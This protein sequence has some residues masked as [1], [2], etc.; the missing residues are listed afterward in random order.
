MYMYF[1]TC[2]CTGNARVNGCLSCL[3]ASY[4][5]HGPP[6]CVFALLAVFSSS[7]VAGALSAFGGVAFLE[8]ADGGMLL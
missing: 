1:N 6:V 3:Y 2:T 7:G 4:H 5:W 8:S